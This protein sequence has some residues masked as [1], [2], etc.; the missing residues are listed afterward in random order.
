MV[1]KDCSKQFGETSLALS[2]AQIPFYSTNS[3][4]S[5]EVLK[6]CSQKLYD[7]GNEQ[8]VC[9][10]VIMDGWRVVVSDVACPKQA[11][12]NALE[13]AICKFS[14]ILFSK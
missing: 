3:A 5:M 1:C 7:E 11:E 4:S 2:L 6:R 13:L 12:A 10:E 14:K 8:S 9:I